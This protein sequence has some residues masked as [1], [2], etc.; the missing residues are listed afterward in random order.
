[1][2]TKVF[3]MTIRIIF[4]LLSSLYFHCCD[5]CHYEEDK[6]IVSPDN[7]YEI[8]CGYQSC[9]GAAGSMTALVFLA[10]MGTPIEKSRWV[11]EA[12]HVDSVLASWV[13]DNSILIKC[14][15][16]EDGRIIDRKEEIEIHDANEKKRLLKVVLQEK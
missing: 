1:M 2:T 8:I 9:G 7:K 6:R 11:V 13:N 3:S 5:E 10:P 12:V 16:G 14:Y 15:L 4:V